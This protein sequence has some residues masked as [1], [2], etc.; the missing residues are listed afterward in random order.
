MIN[1]W[2][3]RGHP[4]A[5]TTRLALEISQASCRIAGLSARNR[6]CFTAQELVAEGAQVVITGLTPS[7]TAR[8][9]ESLGGVDRAIGVIG[10]NSDPVTADMLVQTALQTFGRLDGALISV[11]G[12]PP[13]PSWTS[14]TSSGAARSR[15]SFSARYG[16]PAPSEER[17]NM[18]L[19]SRSYSRHRSER[20]SPDPAQ[21]AQWRWSAD[22]APFRS[23]RRETHQY[24]TYP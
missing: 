22:A 8:A 16:S 21:A 13:V 14:M 24:L 12:P 20:P 5:E 10:D 19:P 18:T 11:G 17:S 23:R 15:R 6:S 1:G 2:I 9:A 3:R 7:D 4:A